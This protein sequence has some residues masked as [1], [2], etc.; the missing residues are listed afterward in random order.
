[1]KNRSLIASLLMSAMSTIG[2]KTAAVNHPIKMYTHAPSRHRRGRS[3][4]HDDARKAGI[5]KCLRQ[6]AKRYGGL[7]VEGIL[8]IDRQM[9][10]TSIRATRVA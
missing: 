3:S 9:R 7:D 5:P 2:F 10:G 1:M 4:N 8:Q 6:Y